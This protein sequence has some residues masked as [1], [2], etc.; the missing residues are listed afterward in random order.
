MV[1]KVKKVRGKRY[2]KSSVKPVNP[3]DAQRRSIRRS[4][5]LLRDKY[6]EQL[7]LE[8]EKAE[9]KDRAG[10][11]AKYAKLRSDLRKR[12]QRQLEALK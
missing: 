9:K 7:A 10:I 5:K 2:M 4:A 11:R 12:I 1:K 3:K 6:K 8:L